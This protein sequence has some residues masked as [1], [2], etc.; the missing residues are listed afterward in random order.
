MNNY[1]VQTRYAATATVAAF[2][3]V[4]PSM[5]KDEEIAGQDVTPTIRFNGV[6]GSMPSVSPLTIRQ[7]TEQA[8]DFGRLVSE[9]FSRL[10]IRQNPLEPALARALAQNAWDLYEEA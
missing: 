6:I 9:V 3:L 8:D 5:H 10:A 1:V 7:V 4:G 2:M